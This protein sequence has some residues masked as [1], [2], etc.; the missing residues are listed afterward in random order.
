MKNTNK[1]FKNNLKPG[2]MFIVKDTKN[3]NRLCLVV[4]VDKSENK[5]TLYDFYC[6]ASFFYPIS[7]MNVEALQIIVPKPKE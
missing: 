6:G 4:D 3:N 7:G 2:F 5:Y 1:D